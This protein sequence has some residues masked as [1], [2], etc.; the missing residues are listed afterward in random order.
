MKELIFRNSWH[1]TYVLRLGIFRYVYGN[2]L[3]ITAES[4][5][6]IEKIW[7][8][9]TTI[10]VNLEDEVLP[11]ENYAFVDTNNCPDIY[12]FL[13]ENG[14]GKPTGEFGFSGMCA[15][16]LFVFDLDNLRK[17]CYI[18]RYDATDGHDKH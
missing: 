11:G 14:I 16:P 4:Y 18:N 13:V 7:L 5:D 2:S 6:E 1:V 15:Y 17:I 3:A 10:T 9:F 12:A 8:P